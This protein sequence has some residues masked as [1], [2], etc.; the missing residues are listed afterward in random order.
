MDSQDRQSE[1]LAWDCKAGAYENALLTETGLMTEQV[2]S[3]GA[4][5][6][7]VAIVLAVT[8]ALNRKRKNSAD[9]SLDGQVALVD[10]RANVRKSG[11]F[12]EITLPTIGKTLL[13]ENERERT[14]LEARLLQAGYYNRQA[15]FIY[16]GIKA[17]LMLAPWLLGLA[18]G[19]LGLVGITQGVAAGA[20]LSFLG[21][22]A[23]GMWLNRRKSERQAA[24]RAG[25]PDL[26]DVLVICL[27]AGLSL[28]DGLRRVIKDLGAAH[29]S[30]RTDL[31]IIQREMQLGR[32][33]GQALHK[34]AERFDLQEL[35]N[36]AM[37]VAQSDRYGGGLVK[38]LRLQTESLRFQRM[39]KMEEAAQKAG[40]KVLLPTLLFIFPGIFVI[41]LGP[42]AMQVGELMSK[43]K[44]STAK[45]EQVRDHRKSFSKIYTR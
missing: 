38:S 25:L 31:N 30:L 34:L 28:G 3:Q 40:T 14:R 10:K 27:E 5:L 4:Y 39:Q 17:V 7:T 29:P 36:L 26:L 24:C 6:L 11:S 35:R 44:S 23:P 22:T 1:V 33:A 16:L 21:M 43:M 18:A 8:L 37:T 12:A 19:L 32:T 13:P 42:A 20:F 45:T 2:F 15:L 9:P 41:L